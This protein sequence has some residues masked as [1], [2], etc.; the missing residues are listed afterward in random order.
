MDRPL[1]PGRTIGILGGG[2]L[3]RMTAIAARRIGYRT[4]VLDPDPASPGAQVSDGHVVGSLEDAAAMQALAREADVVTYEFENVSAEA[5]EALEAWVPVHP[6]SS[7]LR[8]SQH[9][10]RE[11]TAVSR[12][13]APVP[14]FRA[15]TSLPEL[16]EALGALVFPLVMKTATGGYDGKGQAVVRNKAEAHS[17]FSRLMQAADTLI[18]EQQVD[19]ACELSV[20]CARDTDGML[21]TY[22]ASQNRHRDGILDVTTAPAAVD[23]RVSQRADAIARSIAAGLELVGLLAVE[24]FVDR[25]GEVLVNEVAP[26][27]HNSGHHTIEAAATSQFEQLVRILAGLPLGDTRIARPAAMANLLGDLW[28]ADG[29]PPDFARMLAVPGVRLHL[30]GKGEARPGR[31]MGHVTALGDSVDEALSLVLEARGRAAGD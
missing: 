25:S 10:I 30:Y 7:I 9:R 4:V 11:K 5:V 17:A 22:P 23:P 3:G 31:K 26:R 12:F 1:P 19:L 2:Q 27:P 20:I 14:A 13:G 18:I 8:V 6:S 15:V 24:M 28:R 21:A 16:D 29:A